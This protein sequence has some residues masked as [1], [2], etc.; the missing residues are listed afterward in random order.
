[1]NPLKD[2]GWNEALA[3]EFE[4]DYMAEL[5]AFLNAEKAAGTEVYPSGSRIFAA[6]DTTPLAGVRVVIVGQDPYHGPGQAMGLSFSVRPGI[7]LPPS[8]RNIFKE[9]VDDV[10][11]PHPPNGDL[12]PW[13]QRGVL[14]LNSVLTVRRGEAASH[15]GR[16]WERFTDRVIEVINERRE[17]VVFILW[18]RHAKEKGITIDRD[19]HHVIS[20]VHPSPLS[21]RH[22]FFGSRPFSRTNELLVADG[23]E[24][25]DWNLAQDR[26]ARND[27]ARATV[28]L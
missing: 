12:T 13:A 24:P 5:S 9:L 16:G 4:A 14:L 18:G 26:E 7:G 2:P 15:A 21:A 22:G 28:G 17:R 11:C 23:G 20:S 6:L 3:A 25:I 27:G 10:G 1:M 19:R 8:L